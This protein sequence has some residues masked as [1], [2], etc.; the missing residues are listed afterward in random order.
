MAQDLT[1]MHAVDR[2]PATERA[3]Q[4]VPQIPQIRDVVEIPHVR[5]VAQI[6]QVRDVVQTS[7]VRDEAQI[8]QVRPVPEVK[9]VDPYLSAMPEAVAPWTA[10]AATHSSG[11]LPRAQ[12]ASTTIIDPSCF[13]GGPYFDVTVDALLWRLEPTRGQTMFLNPVAGTSVR[14]DD[15]D[16]GFQAGPRIAM[17]FLSDDQEAIHSLEIGYF[18][19]Y[20]WFDRINDVAPAGTFLCLPDRL[21]DVGVTTDFSA[22]DEMQARYNVRLN[23][24]EANIYFGN[25][26][27][28]FCWAIGPRFIRMEER[29]NLNSITGAR[30]SYYDV[31]TG[32]DLWGVQWVGRWR[33]TRGCWE[34][35]GICK[36][37]IYDNQARQSTLMTDNDRTVVL[38]NFSDTSTVASFVLDAGVTLGYQVTDTWLA[39]VGY[40][41]FVLDNVARATDQLDFSNNATS[42]DR[43]FLRQDAVAHGLNFGIEGRW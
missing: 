10:E 35:T 34:L 11:V 8:P 12:G 38:R 7:Q 21:G 17:E 5:D 41:V 39:R 40:S 43:V 22:A 42:G 37:G 23:S 28:E 30:Y 32:N 14:T 25:Q 27:S 16:L 36:V 9:P 33:R 4:E 13:T 20:N 3:S 31:D 1:P 24:V 19:I 15:L 6:P 26:R 2:A 29:F 18:G